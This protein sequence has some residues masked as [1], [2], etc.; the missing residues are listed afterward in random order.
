MLA[1][2]LRAL[3]HHPSF[4]SVAAHVAE[5]IFDALMDVV[6]AVE[7]FTA[8]ANRDSYAENFIT[9]VEKRIALQQVMEEQHGKD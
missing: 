4:E 3:K 6:E 1:D 2:D 8:S 9:L 7:A 5:E